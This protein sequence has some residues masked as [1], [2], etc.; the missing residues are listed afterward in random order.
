[1]I[2]HPGGDSFWM[3]GTAMI[4]RNCKLAA[5]ILIAVLVHAAIFAATDAGLRAANDALKSF[6]PADLGS[7]AYTHRYYYGFA[8]QA[9]SGRVPYRDFVFEYPVLAFPLFFIPHLLTSDFESYRLA[10]VVEMFL[11]DVAAI[12]LIAGHGGEKEEVGTVAR[13]LAWYTLY[14]ALLAPLMIGRYDL[15]PTVLAFA[16]A[17]WWFSGRNIAGGVAAGLGTLMKIFP[18]VVAAP[19][20][21][22]EASQ[23]RTTR[24]RG[25]VAFL[26]TLAIGVA[27]WFWLGG[28]RTFESLGYHT[29]RGL[30]VESL[31]GGA[32]FLVGSIVGTK[33]PWVNNYDAFHVVPEWGARLALVA[34][35]LQAAALLVVMWRFRRSGM[36]DGVRCSAAAVLAFI[37][38][39]KV[40]S[41]QYLIWLCPFMAVLDGR[42][43][44]VARKIFLL[45]CLTAAMFYPGPGY[46]MA[47]EH[48]A[49][50]ILLLNLRNTLLLLLLAV[51]LY[52]PEAGP[53]IAATGD[54]AQE[55]QRFPKDSQPLSSVIPGAA[56][57]VD[58]LA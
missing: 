1:M 42:T 47:L 39:C 5:C 16:A 10:F 50:A 46:A 26:G 57:E 33:V 12:V 49:G 7:V 58:M 41:P 43:G 40:L 17:R 31:Y 34:F 8:S 2:A 20:L 15:A 14:C 35:P 6:G 53:A 19:A 3:S 32:L 13:R 11:F 54:V 4:T 22:W 25:M 29:R 36:A 30:E 48:R 28:S 56:G 9:L 38:F 52:D 51:L 55:Y 45:A 24:T 37:V 27:I 18:G 44:S 23:F 21:V